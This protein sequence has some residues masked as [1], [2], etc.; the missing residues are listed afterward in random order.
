MKVDLAP[1]TADMVARAAEATEF[2]KH[3]AHPT[4]LMVACALIDA[5]RSVRDLEDTLA[6]RQPGLSQQLAE[7]REAGL[8]VGRKAGKHMFYRLADDR[9]AGFIAVMY[10][11]FCAPHQGESQGH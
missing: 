4:R 8:I 11:L 6:I 7:L 9:V 2:L 10:R 1:E 3:F 5:E